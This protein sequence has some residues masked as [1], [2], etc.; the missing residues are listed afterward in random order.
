MKT[1]HR[2]NIKTGSYE[3][4]MAYFNAE[5]IPMASDLM[6]GLPGQTVDSVQRDLQFCFDWKVSAH[7]NYTSMMPNAPMAEPSY[8]AEHRIVTDRAGMVASTASFDQRDMEYMKRLYASYQFHVRFG[9]LKYYLYVLQIDYGVAAIGLLRSWLDAVLAGDPRLPLGSLLY[10]RILAAKGDSEDW[11][12]MGWGDDAGFLFDDI[13]AYYR[14]VHA[15]VESVFDTGISDPECLALFAAQ[16]AVMP[17]R[18]CD[19]PRLVELQH[20]V[21]AYFRQLKEYPSIR[22]LGEDYRSLRDFPAG[23]L[24]IPRGKRGGTLRF[25]QIDGHRDG[26]ELRSPLRFY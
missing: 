1:I 8:R 18:D 6:V 16:A 4:M 13:Q 15:F 9:V 25:Q 2:D 7:A 10:R 21:Q 22:D 14:E 26:W 23:R 24:R 17:C 5:G 19:Y 20:D 12:L 3:K 11:A